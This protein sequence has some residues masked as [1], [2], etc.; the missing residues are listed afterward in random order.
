MCV[1]CACCFVVGV[2]GVVGVFVL[3]FLG[4]W[5]GCVFVCCGV[6]SGDWL[7]GGGGGWVGGVVFVG[8]FFC[9]G[10][11]GCGVWGWVGG[12]WGGGGG[13]PPFALPQVGTTRNRGE[14]DLSGRQFSISVFG[15]KL[16]L[17]NLRLSRI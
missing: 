8:G 12:C 4:C 5:V 13:Y 11:G 7:F 15:C 10:V 14:R 3:G 17:V 1:L 6:L 16:F 2:V 9:V